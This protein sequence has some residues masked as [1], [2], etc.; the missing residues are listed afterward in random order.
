[1]L[2]R[3]LGG[4][5]VSAIGFGAMQ[6]PG[7][8]VMGPPDDRDAALAVLRRAVELG[9]DHVDTA[10]YY[11]PDVSNELIHEA[12]APYPDGLRIVTK[13]GARRDEQGGWL[14]ALAPDEVR[15]AVDDNLRSLGVERLAMVNLRL[16]GPD[17]P[18]EEALGVLAELRDAGKLELIGMSEVTAEQLDAAQAVTEIAS[19]QNLLNLLQRDSMDVLRAC[20]QRGLAFTPYFPLG[21]AFTSAPRRIARLDAVRAAAEAHG[22]TPAQVSLAWLLGLGEHVLLIPGTSSL[23]HLEENL[24]AADLALT[25]EELSALDAAA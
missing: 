17:T 11:G 5:P 8:G 3:T 13:I 4:R 24:A 23:E 16:M 25:A 20:E 6:L 10:Q 19:V 22:A 18:L 7:K 21:S 2:Q 1:M 14:P 15:Q 12:L 9:V